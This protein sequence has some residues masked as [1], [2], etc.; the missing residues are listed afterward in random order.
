MHRS[1]TET[2][3]N[4][5]LISSPR[6]IRL[7]LWSTFPFQWKAASTLFR[8]IIAINQL[9]N[10]TL[11]R[12]PEYNFFPDNPQNQLSPFRVQYVRPL[13]LNVRHYQC[14]LS[15]GA[16]KT[17]RSGPNISHSLIS[18]GRWL[19]TALLHNSGAWN[20]PSFLSKTPTSLLYDAVNHTCSNYLVQAQCNISMIY[21]CQI[22]RRYRSYPCKIHTSE[23]HQRPTRCSPS[24][25]Q[26]F[27]LSFQPQN[28][29]S[30]YY[31]LLN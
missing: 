28:N 24:L 17:W 16:P 11:R 31:P 8:L 1:R 15:C 23:Q 6:S 2:P 4:K 14:R 22:W 27:L 19:I 12:S 25:P 3:N 21:H 10:Q 9:A 7:S 26:T 20:V 29:T 5:N 13:K 18:G 30:N